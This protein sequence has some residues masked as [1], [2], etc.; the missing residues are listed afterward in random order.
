MKEILENLKDYFYYEEKENNFKR[1]EE[2]DLRFYINDKNNIMIEIKNFNNNY[3]LLSLYIR[4]EN[5]ILSKYE[6]YNF[7]DLLSI[8]Q[9]LY[10]NDD[11]SEFL[12]NSIELF[13]DKIFLE[14]F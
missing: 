3:F 5:I 1:Y 14:D 10:N 11:I 8:N 12:I 6:N 4:N 2:D 13:I 7:I 9:I